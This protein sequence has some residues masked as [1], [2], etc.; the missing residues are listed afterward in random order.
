MVNKIKELLY[1]ILNEKYPV[2]DYL[3]KFIGAYKN[4]R[5]S[6]RISNFKLTASQ[7]L[8]LISVKLVRILLYAV[9]FNYLFKHIVI[10]YTEMFSE[11]TNLSSFLKII[12][13]F[14]GA[15]IL[16]EILDKYLY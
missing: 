7:K 1:Y 6:E 11:T 3:A 2:I 12:F 5:E 10:P 14:I 13:S 15:K 9:V 16:E 4:I 8:K